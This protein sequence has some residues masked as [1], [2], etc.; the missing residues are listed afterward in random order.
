M[1]QE[2]ETGRRVPP[3]EMET[4][5]E[6]I[7]VAY[8]LLQRHPGVF[9]GKQFDEND[10]DD[11]D[12][13]KKKRADDGDVSE[14][15]C[16]RAASS[17]IASLYR[18][19]QGSALSRENAVAAGVTVAAAVGAGVTD[20]RR[21]AAAL[22]DA[23]A[24][25]EPLTGSGPLL[26]STSSSAD[27]WCR[28]NGVAPAPMEA[29]ALATETV[30]KETATAT[31]KVTQQTVT[32]SEINNNTEQ[33]KGM[34][35]FRD[36]SDRMTPFGRLCAARGVLTAASAEA[37]SFPLEVPAEANEAGRASEGD[38]G[39]ENKEKKKKKPWTLLTSYLFPY[40]CASLERP[41][42]SH[43]KYHAAAALRAALVRVKALAVAAG[44]GPREKKEKEELK[45]PAEL[46]KKF[47]LDDV[48]PPS[49]R[50]RVCDILWANWE[51]P[52]SQTVKETHLSFDTLLDVEEARVAEEG[53]RGS[54]ALP[55][56]FLEDAARSLLKKDVSVKGRYAPLAMVARRLGARRLLA[57]AP[58]LL[59]E[60]L[61]AMRDDSVCTAAGALVAAV[62]QS[63]LAETTDG[64][65]MAEKEAGKKTETAASVRRF[66]E[67]SRSRGS[68]RR[69]GKDEG[70]VAAAGSAAALA[71]WRAW[72][73]GPL[74]E[75]LL[76]PGRERAGAGT[77][78]LPAFLRLDGASVV[79]LLARIRED[80]TLRANAAPAENTEEN[81]NDAT[82]THASRRVSAVAAAVVATLRSARALGLLDPD[83]PSRVSRRV[84]EAAA[85][86]F[87][88]ETTSGPDDDEPSGK[89]NVPTE[90][91]T[92]RT[93]SN[94]VVSYG[95]DASTLLAAATRR[96]ARSRRDALDLLCADGKRASLPGALERKVLRSA[97]P[98]HLRDAD[99]AFRSALVS[100]TTRLLGRIKAG[101][102]RAAVFVRA[103]PELA[104]AFRET[105]D[106]ITPYSTPLPKE[107]SSEKTE[108][109]EKFS[110]T[111]T[112]PQE[113]RGA[114][115]FGAHAKGA[116]AVDDDEAARLIA[117]ASACVEFT[118]WLVKT[119]MR[120]AYPGAPYERKQTAL[121]LLLA[122]AETF[123]VQGSPESDDMVTAASASVGNRESDADALAFA[124]R[125]ASRLE[126]SP[127]ATHCLGSDVVTCL[128][129]A[130]VDSW[131]KLRV[132]AF[133]LLS[134]HPAPLAG[135]ERP[136]AVAALFAWALALSRSP[137]VRESDAAALLLRL[138]FRKYALDGGWT[139]TLT[140]EVVA[141]PPRE[142][143]SVADSQRLA[144]ARTKKKS[145]KARRARTARLLGASPFIR[146]FFLSFFFFLPPVRGAATF[147]RFLLVLAL[148][149][150]NT[151]REGNTIITHRPLML[152]NIFSNMC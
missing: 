87:A 56:A 148:F 57:L 96:D 137:R 146:F 35:T 6:A 122:V 24:E 93:H 64:E 89:T 65:L 90:E 118:E 60:T 76:S 145:E 11:D 127:Y 110:K 32:T 30:T 97:I 19:L 66:D 15:R 70:T 133:R 128:L 152:A 22:A 143:E 1:I 82:E 46:T 147:R 14:T 113:T 18:A 78:A 79:P 100:S 108:V 139:V 95:V 8:A 121:D 23:F 31:R 144:S 25:R 54:D 49:S 103:R 4:C 104:R 138:L 91:T 2:A 45:T 68:L 85:R 107:A 59:T 38:E 84:A 7:S 26:P 21:H 132:G 72:W 86:T 13:V 115:C 29:L 20:P 48:F 9:L 71:S 111:G 53:R 94:S 142:S 74:A 131:D 40:I 134:K 102:G 81:E 75:A 43:H 10:D 140:P 41:G 3:A 149:F 106:R 16:L 129:G 51:D 52:L 28:A 130:A 44:R 80:P 136:E 99:P 126:A 117:N 88:W 61:R 69:A 98:T 141:T 12:D 39:E 73:V 55:T 63:L 42:D 101:C 37:L 150:L 109:K 92:L 124:E 119:L 36:L 135:V 62:A 77:Y 116:R 67:G 27:A 5:Q 112:L 123:G 120:S 33:H 17:M 34:M 151:S 83:D 47:S 50:D 58:D 125:L 114:R 105:H